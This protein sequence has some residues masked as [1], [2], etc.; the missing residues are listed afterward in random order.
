MKLLRNFSMRSDLAHQ[1]ARVSRKC[2]RKNQEPNMIKNIK[3][4][5]VFLPTTNLQIEG[6]VKPSSDLI[7]Q[8][9][10]LF[11]YLKGIK[12]NKTIGSSVS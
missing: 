3:L 2:S 6:G 8:L 10:R 4:K 5:K 7:N 11:Y 12:Q 9:G 1:L